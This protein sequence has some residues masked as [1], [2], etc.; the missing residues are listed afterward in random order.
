MD[1]KRSGKN[2]KMSDPAVLVRL[3][4]LFA[5]NNRSTLVS[6]IILA[7]VDGTRP[8]VPIVL[9]GLLID[10][11]ASGAGLGLIFRYVAVGLAAIFLLQ[12]LSSWLR[13]Y[14][15]ARVENCMERQNR[16][17]NE[18]SMAIDYEHLE[19]PVVQ[20]KKRR[21]EQVVNVRGGIY[22]MLIWPLDR[23]LTGLI[24]VVTALV[25]AVPMFVGNAEG[26]VRALPGAGWMTPVLFLV[27]AACVIINY[28]SSRLSN[29]AVRGKFD[30]YADCSRVSNYFLHD[31]LAGSETAKDLRI[32]HQ[33]KLV[34][35]GVCAREEEARGILYKMRTLWMKQECIERSV[36]NI[37]GGC[38][39][40]YAALKAYMGLISI[41]S[42]VRYAGSIIKCVEGFSEVLLGISAWREA[43]DY[44]RDYLEYID[45][46]NHKDQGSLP[47]EQ[48]ENGRFL[49]EFDHV[50]FKYPGSEEYVIRDLSLKL[51][52]GERMAIVGRNG[53]GKT[54]FIKL[55]CRL[56]DV[57]EGAVR[58]NG[59]NIRDYDYEEYMKLFSVVFQDYRIFSLKLGENVAS[60][61]YVDEERAADALAR[62]GLEERLAQLADGLDTYVGKEFDEHGVNFSGGERQKA[63]IARAIYKGA[64]FVIMDE[65]TA[66]LDPVS[67]CAVYA[68]FDKMVGRKTA[69]YISH[70]L[71][72][73]RFCSDI[74]VFDRGKVIQ[75]GSHDKL[76]QEEGMYRNLWNAQAQYYEI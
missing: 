7:L 46:E 76:V 45:F 27:L 71:A 30:E 68:G 12:M 20:E 55:L 70:R 41:G 9:S 36:S 61:E 29:Q 35:D 57:T 44:G 43:A 13:E 42:V 11:L 73:C 3:Y 51:D 54:T 47:L 39:Y 52:I 6:C 72:S 23:G 48:M 19:D 69:V 66:A 56:Y 58:L 32:F 15:N 50:S 24:S 16:D 62:A 64:P 4:A 53:S 60:S 38:V 2:K 34:E 63:A 26:A 1:G 74:L 49:I 22:W 75:R 65:P 18:E 14:F 33:E 40:L 21:Q 5:R 28:R 37:C 31:I 8:Y 67:E 17:M 59:V 10:A 25:V